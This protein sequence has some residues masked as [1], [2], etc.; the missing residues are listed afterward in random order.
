MFV[1]VPGMLKLLFISLPLSRQE[2]VC[3]CGAQERELRRAGECGELPGARSGPLP[4]LPARLPAASDV[5]IRGS[6]GGRGGWGRI[7]FS[8]MRWTAVQVQS[9]S[10]RDLEAEISTMAEETPLAEPKA[11]KFLASWEERERKSP[12]ERAKSQTGNSLR[13]FD[14][15]L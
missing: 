2:L 6:D 7:M 3:L 10:L 11:Q 12:L 1:T 14:L 5:S 15:S 8:C 4:G 13:R 9:V